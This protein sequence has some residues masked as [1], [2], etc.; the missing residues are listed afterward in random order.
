MTHHAGVCHAERARVWCSH[1]RRTVRGNTSNASLALVVDRD[2]RVMLM[3]ERTMS[4]PSLSIAVTMLLALAGCQSKVSA[5][6]LE[7]E[8]IKWLAEQELV[9]SQATCPDKQKLDGGHVFECTAVVD[10]V[11]IPIRVEVINPSTGV[12][13]WTPKYKT[14]TR[15]QIE[16]SIRALPEFAG[17]ELALDCHKAVFVS[18]PK[19]KITCDVIDQGT[20]QAYVASFEFT[21]GQ[22]SGTWQLDPPIEIPQ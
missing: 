1:P 4:R 7:T 16:D 5:D 10:G 3:F 2:V 17:R 11:E 22:G 19:S 12:V 9:A 20:A 18:V 14:F 8:L 6:T 13:A 21:D 15:P